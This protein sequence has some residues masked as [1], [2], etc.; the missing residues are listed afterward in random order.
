M[1]L[2]GTNTITLTRFEIPNGTT[3]LN[4][5]PLQGLMQFTVFPTLPNMPDGF[6]NA[7]AIDFESLAG[8]PRLMIFQSDGRFVD[9]AGNV[10][11]GT[12]FLGVPGDSTTAR[13]MTVLGATGRIRAYC[14][15]S[16]KWIQ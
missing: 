7:R 8:G 11:K 13:A 2:V 16:A 9:N 15:P 3:L 4:T 14:A 10:I 6:G 1:Q 12:V 5:V